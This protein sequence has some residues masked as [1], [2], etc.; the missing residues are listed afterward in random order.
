MNKIDALKKIEALEKETKELRKIIENNSLTIDNIKSVEDLCKYLNISEDEVYLFDKNTKDPFE[1]YINA[2]SI[3]P[4][5]TKVFN[6]S[7]IANFT[8]SNQYKYLPYYKLSSL[9]WSFD[10]THTWGSGTDASVSHYYKDSN[11]C[12][13]ACSIFN[14]IYIDYHSYKG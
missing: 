8:N 10:A 1:K 4:K 11:T 9:G 13:K 5:I 7:W 2:C 12:K 6:E 14:N 3:I